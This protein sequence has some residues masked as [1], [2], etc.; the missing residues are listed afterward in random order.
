MLSDRE[1]ETSVQTELSLV[2][3]RLWHASVTTNFMGLA[4]AHPFDTSSNKHFLVAHKR[5]LTSADVFAKQGWPAELARL[6]LQAIKA[7]LSA[8]VTDSDSLSL[9][10]LERLAQRPES[11]RFTARGLVVEFNVYEI[12]SY[13]SGPQEV[14]LAWSALEPLLN[15]AFREELTLIKGAGAQ[16]P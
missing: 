5:A 10:E 3:P 8:D 1:S 15:P 7:Q 6:T 16:S 14:T 4:A 2:T 11:W 9:K 13:A 12:A